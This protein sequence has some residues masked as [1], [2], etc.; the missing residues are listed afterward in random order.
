MTWEELSWSEWALVDDAGKILGRVV[1]SG[2]TYIAYSSI[3]A[4]L[5]EYISLEQAKR[6]LDPDELR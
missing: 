4:P 6:A 2:R 1:R 3:A 5:G